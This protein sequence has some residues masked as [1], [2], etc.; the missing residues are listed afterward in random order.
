MADVLIPLA[1]QTHAV[2]LCNGGVG[3]CIL[4]DSF[5]R[6]YSVQ[7]AK[8]GGS[9]P[10]T[11]LSMVNGIT[12]LY[13]NPDEGAHWRE[14]R[15]ASRT[16]R[17]R[18][19]KLTEVFKPVEDTAMSYRKLDLD[20]NATCIIITDNVH[21]KKE[22]FDVSPY[23]ALMAALVRHL[24]NTIPSIAIRTGGSRRG[25][26]GG[27]APDQ[28]NMVAQRAQSGTPVL[29]LDVRPRKPLTVGADASLD[30]GADQRASQDAAGVL[31]TLRKVARSTSTAII[32]EAGPS[33]AGATAMGP[34]YTTSSHGA[35]AS[36]ISAAKKNLE[37]AGKEFL[38]AGLT[39]AFDVCT[40][41]YMHEVLIGGVDELLK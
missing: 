5:T 26:L 7:R 28:L 9:S 4:S 30:Q 13:A 18:D 12:D 16:W 35:R 23:A 19:A 40:M 31:P 22:G 27:A 17:Q 11:V 1:A 24:S 3:E 41:A 29:C 20:P 6:M 36:L 33:P 38:Q 10:F 15:K 8:W 2:V 21:P 14:V 39:E 25:V 34:V 37:A 32:G